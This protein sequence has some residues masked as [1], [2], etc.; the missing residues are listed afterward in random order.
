MRKGKA[1]LLFVG[2]ILIGGLLGIKL[3]QN[4]TP[5]VER[6]VTKVEKVET[7][8]NLEELLDEVPKAYGVDRRII[9]TIVKME[10][11]NNPDAIRY[12]PHH[13]SRAKKITRNKSK[14]RMY[15][16]S[17]GYMQIMGW[18]AIEYNLS[19]ADLYDPRTN[20]E[21]GTKLFSD[22]LERHKNKPILQQLELAGG[23]YNGSKAY[24]VK[25]VNNLGRALIKEEFAKEKDEK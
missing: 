5:Y 22:C 12:E 4:V 8:P 3:Q 18:H 10:S 21:L 17:I 11:N 14:Q 6:I 15:A 20:I 2:L 1:V 25:L 23:C 13:L 24:G 9:A 16:S 7:K 19:Y